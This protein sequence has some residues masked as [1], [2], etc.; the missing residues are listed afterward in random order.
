MSV[1]QVIKVIQHINDRPAKIIESAYENVYKRKSEWYGV[2][3]KEL[4]YA[5]IPEVVY[6]ENSIPLKKEFKDMLAS[7][8]QGSHSVPRE[9]Q[10]NSLVEDYKGEGQSLARS[11]SGSSRQFFTANQINFFRYLKGMDL[12]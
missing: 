8:Y 4:F 6:K 3:N 2:A 10:R 7:W 12:Y 11:A 1:E 9:D 5:S